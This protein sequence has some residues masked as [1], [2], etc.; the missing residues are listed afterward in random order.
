MFPPAGAADCPQPPKDNKKKNRFLI[1]HDAKTCG[2]DRLQNPSDK[3]LILYVLTRSLLIVLF[4]ILITTA[5]WH[6]TNGF[7]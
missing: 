7:F 3:S 5:A 6:I 4:S 1:T 2:L